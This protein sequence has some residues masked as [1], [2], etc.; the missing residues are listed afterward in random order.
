MVT[1][2][3]AIELVEKLGSI[4]EVLSR[5]RPVLQLPNR[6]PIKE[7]V[8]VPAVKFA[9]RAALAAPSIVGPARR[10]KQSDVF[11]ALLA[12]WETMPIGSEDV[13]EH[14]LSWFLSNET[15]GTALVPIMSYV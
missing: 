4:I 11:E 10:R 2:R 1:E 15:T 13:K 7:V 5:G 6:K 9:L 8:S 3:E 12:G 14:I